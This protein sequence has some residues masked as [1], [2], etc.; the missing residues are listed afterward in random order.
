VGASAG[1]GAR[2]GARAGEEAR[3]GVGAGAGAGAG[4]QE[5]VG[6]AAG[7]GTGEGLGARTIVETGEGARKEV[8][9]Q[10]QQLHQNMHPSAKSSSYFKGP[11]QLKDCQN[12]TKNCALKNG[13][14]NESL[15]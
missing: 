13:R 1:A 10:E 4:M 6:A 15:Q 3:A 11:K 7:G 8:K 2:A 12:A 14:V 9:E 5:V